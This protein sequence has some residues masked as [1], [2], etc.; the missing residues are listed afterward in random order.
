MM[1]VAA[2]GSARSLWEQ[3]ALIP[4]QRGRKGRQY[5]LPAVVTLTLA[6]MLARANDLRAVFR[7]GRRLPPGALGLLGLDRAPYHA[8]HHPFYKAPDVA[9]AEAVL[10]PW[11][12]GGGPAGRLALDGKRLRGSAPAGRDGSAEVHRKRC[13]VAIL[14]G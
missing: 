9:A 6:A 14:P 12:R 7:W 8:V 5:G 1:G 11:E 3:L 10:G 4:D 2:A 13:G